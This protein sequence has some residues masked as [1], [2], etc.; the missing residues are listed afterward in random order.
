[1]R[2]RRRLVLFTRFHRIDIDVDELEVV[3]TLPLSDSSS[4]P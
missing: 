1:M 2:R 4:C 3:R